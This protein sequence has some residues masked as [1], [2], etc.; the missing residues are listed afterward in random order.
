MTYRCADIDRMVP[1]LMGVTKAILD[2]VIFV[3]QEESNWPLADGQ[4]LKKKFD[5]IFAAT[6]YTKALEELRKLKSKQVQDVKEMK[7]K[8]EHLKTHKDHAS[9]LRLTAETHNRQAEVYQAKINELEVTIK[10]L[11]DRQ[12]TLDSKIN[13]VA[14]IKEEVMQLQAKHE[15][16]V[17]NNAQMY[18]RL[19]S[20]CGEEDLTLSIEELQNWMSELEPNLASAT[21]TVTRLKREATSNAQ[22][23]AALQEQF[24]KD[25]RTQGRLAAEA[26]AHTRNVQER[27]RYSREVA[28][29]IGISCPATGSGYLDSLT[30]DEFALFYQA[31]QSN[32]DTMRSQLNDAKATHRK[33]D[34]DLSRSLDKANAELSGAVE[35]LR[36]KKEAISQNESRM[37]ELNRQLAANSVNVVAL[38]EAKQ[39]Q[40]ELEGR[41]SAVHANSG[42]MTDLEGEL[43]RFQQE[44]A[45]LTAQGSALRKERDQLAST[46]E[47]ASRL[48]FKLAEAADKEERIESLMTGCRG[49]LESMLGL[50]RGGALPEPHLLKDAI[51]GVAERQQQEA[52]R[53]QAAL[54][55]L[56]AKEAT[57][58]GSMASTR[59][60]LQRLQEEANQ[61]NH[62]ITHAIAGLAGA[63]ADAASNA[64]RLQQQLPLADFEVEAKN[65]A[66][67]LAQLDAFEQISGAITKTAMQSNICMTCARPFVTTTEREA[68]LAR[69][70][71]EAASIPTRK[72]E[73][74]AAIT[75]MEIRLGIL[76]G[77][78]AHCT[79]S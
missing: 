61:L 7:L 53:H 21:A 72:Q 44:L 20:T 11:T 63:G 54:K 65:K 25:L 73:V 30:D 74:Q 40:E 50:P 26:E 49:R 69:Q 47:G 23:V 67:E 59:Q 15:M 39:R 38:E 16:L 68:F 66:T 31:F 64:L 37:D 24:S 71:A 29:G 19:L 58:E 8:L 13:A 36:M 42:K 35:G 62:S 57:A 9:K 77:D 33:I 2:N 5:D 70:S 52:Q 56:Q 46:V 32:L 76:R 34:D 18:A 6:K 43:N 1:S 14:D 3:H 60:Q 22:Q 78:P 48:R 79:T 75:Q 10:Q 27:D 51:Q 45:Q 17:K 4:T 55:D 28:G 12:S 41:L